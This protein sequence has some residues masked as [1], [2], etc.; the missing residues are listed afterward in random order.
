L[1]LAETVIH[2]IAVAAA[3]R[4]GRAVTLDNRATLVHFRRSSTLL[5][6]E[7]CDVPV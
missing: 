7:V 6:F 2:Q 1:D 3:S 4:K 5:I